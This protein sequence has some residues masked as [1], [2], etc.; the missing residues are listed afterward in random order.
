MKHGVW[1][2]CCIRHAAVGEVFAC[3]SVPMNALNTYCGSKDGRLIDTEK[4]CHTFAMS[5]LL[6]SNS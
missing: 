6:G 2:A 5:H 4:V 3:E 1:T